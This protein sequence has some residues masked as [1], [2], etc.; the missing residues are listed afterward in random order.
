MDSGGFNIK[1]FVDGREVGAYGGHSGVPAGQTL[2]NGNSQ[3][4]WS[5]N[6]AG[7]HTV[8]FT[9]DVDNHVQESNEQDNSRTVTVQVS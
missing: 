3:F 9:V 6:A 2:L 5:F 7:S 8:T 4:T 1:W